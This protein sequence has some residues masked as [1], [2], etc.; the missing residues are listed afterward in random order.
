VTIHDIIKSYLAA[1]N[2]DGLVSEDGCCACVINDLAPCGDPKMD[3]SG[4]VEVPCDGECDDPPCDFHIK[5]SEDKTK[6][7]P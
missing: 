4:G 3:C 7:T 1:N 5:A 2:L 6:E